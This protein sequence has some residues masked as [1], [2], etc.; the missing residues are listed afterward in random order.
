M[1]CFEDCLEALEKALE[2]ISRKLEIHEVSQKQRCFLLAIALHRLAV[3][4]QDL[5]PS[6]VQYRALRARAVS[7]RAANRSVLSA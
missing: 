3:N 2:F 1:F 7:V 6:V 4:S 5:V